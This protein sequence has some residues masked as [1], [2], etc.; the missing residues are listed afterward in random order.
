MSGRSARSAATGGQPARSR[1]V[2]SCRTGLPLIDDLAL[3]QHDDL[4]GELSHD[5]QVVLIR[6]YDTSVRM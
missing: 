1:W 5:G 3:P 2:Y 6:T 4:L